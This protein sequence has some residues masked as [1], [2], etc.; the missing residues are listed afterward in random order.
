MMLYSCIV[1]YGNSGRPRVYYPGEPRVAASTCPYIFVYSDVQSAA[2][3]TVDAVVAWT[4]RAA[5]CLFSD[6]GQ[7]SSNQRSHL[8][9]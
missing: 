4:D 2:M 7:L 9:R 5:R 6:D 3:C 8:R 1:P